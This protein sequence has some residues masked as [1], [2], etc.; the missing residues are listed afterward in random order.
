M[1]KACFVLAVF[2]LPAISVFAQPNAGF[3][4]NHKML[5]SGNVIADKNFYL[6]TAIGHFPDL[7]KLLAEDSGLSEIF[8]QRRDLLATHASD[9][10]TALDTLLPGFMWSPDD[11]LK[12]DKRLGELYEQNTRAFDE[13]IDNE[14][15]PSGA[16]QLFVK[17]TNK[18]FLLKTWAQYMEGSNYIIAQF[19]LGQ[20]MRYPSIDSASYPVNSGYYRST[21]KNLF[22]FLN[23]QASDMKLFY[24]PSLHMA[25][26]LMVLNDRNE[27]AAFEPLESG[28]N[29]AAVREIKK[30]DWKKYQYSAILVPG[31]GPE[32]YGVAIS[33]GGKLRC[34]L[35]AKRFKL[36]LAPF[37][38][39][40]GGYCHPFHT[41]FN[42]ALEMKQYL[43]KHLGIPA[44]AIIIEPQARHTTTNFRNGTRLMIRYGI[45]LNKMAL[46]VTTID[47]ARYIEDQRFDKR[48][49]KE[50]GYLPYSDKK[51]LS[52]HELAFYPVL[53]CLH[54]DPMDPLDP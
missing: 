27:P 51:R 52:A 48:N 36:G 14:L 8:R 12:L 50:L 33:P 38:I 19:G 3:R 40:S 15:R 16:Y 44:K 28:E 10:T 9:K 35:V 37:I 2:L 22:G 46:C 20:K 43:I 4:Q 18:E 1:I 21:V 23:E 54:L 49:V 26:W 5:K 30:T 25:L 39:V 29:Q 11:S 7:K 31:E 42:E 45:P 13:M 24:E 47:Q 34:E 53:D 32:I 41:P 6:L 17:L